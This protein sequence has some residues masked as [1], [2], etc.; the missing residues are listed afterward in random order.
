MSKDKINVTINHQQL[1][2]REYIRQC[3]DIRL[4]QSTIEQIDSDAQQLFAQLQYNNASYTESLRAINQFIIDHVLPMQF[5]T[6]SEY[7]GI[8]GCTGCNIL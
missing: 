1:F 2:D 7:R 8:D 3:G 4:P 6:Y 5:M